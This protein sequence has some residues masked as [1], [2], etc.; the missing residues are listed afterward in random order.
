MPA[1]G[2]RPARRHQ[3][4][5]WH[6]VGEAR[7][8]QPSAVPRPEG[9]QREAALQEAAGARPRSARAADAASLIVHPTPGGR[10]PARSPFFRL[11]ADLTRVDETRL[12]IRRAPHRLGV[13]VEETA[14]KT[15][16]PFVIPTLE[17]ERL[18]LRP[19]R[20]GDIDDYA[21]L[22]ADPEVMRNVGGTWDRSRSWR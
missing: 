6:P 1:S 16:D 3:A 18:R 15:I 11:C 13:M 4:A 19:L 12:A 21:A 7:R 8:V 22:N 14:E 10:A 2:D 9:E 5:L 17:T 20:R